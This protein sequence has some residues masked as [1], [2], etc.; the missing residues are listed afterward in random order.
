MRG[1]LKA[2]FFAL[3][4][5]IAGTLC[6]S[7]H[8]I[9][10]LRNPHL[11]IPPEG[12]A[13]CVV[14]TARDLPGGAKAEGKPGDYVLRN[15][16]AT[17]VVA[18]PRMTSGYSR[19]GGRLL[20]AVLNEPGHD[21]DMLGEV[22]LATVADGMLFN[23]RVLRAERAEIISAGGR[24]QPAHLRVYAVDDRFPIVDTTL[25]MPTSPQ[26]IA[27]T[28]DY[29]LPPGSPTLQ[30]HLTLR[31]TANQERTLVL[32]WGQILGDG[33]VTLLPPW[34]TAGYALQK[35]GG[36]PL[37]GLV[38]NLLGVFPMAAAVGSRVSYAF[39]NQREEFQQMLQAEQIYLYAANR[40]LRV[41]AEGTAEVRLSV[42]VGEGEMDSLWREV[43]R[44]RRTNDSLQTLKGQVVDHAG[45]AVPGARI[46]LLRQAGDQQQFL[47]IVQTDEQGRWQAE[48]PHGLYRAVVFAEGYS[49]A[50]L[51]LQRE[52]EVR[53]DGPATL[54]LNVCDEKRRPVPCAVVFER[55]SG[56]LSKAER[57]RFGEEGDYG[58]F[59]RVY[60]SLSGNES[61][62]VEPGRYRVTVTRG[63][64]Y[65]VSQ[66]EIDLQAGK[67]VTV[68]AT[69]ERSV[70]LPGYLSGDFHV[71]A[72]P[73]P[74]SNDP[75]A[76]KVKAYVAMG[77]QILTATDH[78]V[79]TDYQPVIRHLGV[80]RWITSVIGC[81]ISPNFGV[82][83]FNAYPQRYDPNKPNNGAI[84][85]YDL[86][87]EQIF[88]AARQN[89]DGDTIVQVNHPRGSGA[90]YFGWIGLDPSAGTIARPNEFSPHF[91]A[92]EVFNGT[93]VNQ[94]L[95][96]LSDWFYF[97][98]HGSR[99]AAMANT[100]S[101]HAYRLEPGYPRTYLFF[102]H[103]NPQRVTPQSVVQAIRRGNITLCGG[104]V[105][106]MTAEGRYSL[107]G[108]VASPDGTVRLQVRVQS[109]SWVRV[110]RLKLIVNGK[111]EQELTIDHPDGKPLD[112]QQQ[113]T[114]KVEGDS[115]VIALVEGKGFAALYPGSRPV[116]L[117]NPIYVD[118]GGDG[119]KPA[120]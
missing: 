98:N 75:F 78:D 79:L 30:I 90:A 56:A 26:G 116:S 51:D 114:L 55:L 120:P 54:R 91:D 103:N 97:L 16:E 47:N 15:H 18:A 60:Y 83:H 29:I 23:I 17:F 59:D 6:V 89:N 77:V 112:W 115:W 58:R 118:V 8:E 45:K 24:G 113:V 80:Q 50:A 52:T 22:F 111:V 1:S 14:A 57:A 76:D 31:N 71:H 13:Q 84:S 86:S 117:T 46:Y 41:P 10:K 19:Y 74:D 99:Y 100:D 82:G 70:H 92:I 62:P 63:F 33:L 12:V 109:A 96:V 40:P 102:G 25:R 64:E 38:Q 53:L 49:P 32:F 3:L 87:A 11:P 61:V 20:D 39:F 110:N 119:W 93:D 7:A 48:V 36:Q 101:H 42:S 5:L 4:T 34:G 66:Q 37:L 43:R 9:G 105:V 44:F 2:G 73:S 67:S 85:W 21:E 35:A 108:T 95:Q 94:L 104:P 72:L 65:E 106:T 107:G 28:V 81:E 27:V 69:L 88:S 68:Q